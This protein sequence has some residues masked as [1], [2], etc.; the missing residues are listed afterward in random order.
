MSSWKNASKAYQ[1]P[2]RERHQPE[3]RK[4]LGLLEKKKDYKE[5]AEDYNAKKAQLQYLQRKALDKNP[6]E[7]YFH[8]VNSEVKDGV[9]FDKTKEVTMT[10]EQVKLMQTQ[11]HRYIASRHVIEEKKV[12]SLQARLHNLDSDHPNKHTFFVDDEK[13]LRKFSLTKRLDT[14]AE[15]LHRRYNRLR[16]TDVA[17]KNFQA[18][19]KDAETLKNVAKLRHKAYKELEA[20]T[21]RNKKLA[22][23]ERKI[24]IKK[25]LQDKSRTVKSRLAPE[26]PDS[27]PVYVWK[28]ERK[29]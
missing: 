4:H 28:S 21:G 25:V 10:T 3:A 23:L 8:M 13:E 15:L 9:H 27:A 24:E 26:T 12:K 11:D 20:R 29:R 14:P 1:K 5:R 22:T 18:L 19:A 6:D 16:N 7:F 2:H 17:N